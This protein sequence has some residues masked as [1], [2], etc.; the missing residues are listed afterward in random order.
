VV[1]ALG[2]F[3]AFPDRTTTAAYNSVDAKIS[4]AAAINYTARILDPPARVAFRSGADCS[5]AE[6]TAAFPSDPDIAD[7]GTAASLN[8]R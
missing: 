7:Y 3:N 8:C 1:T 6:Y 4:S 5:V 2:Q